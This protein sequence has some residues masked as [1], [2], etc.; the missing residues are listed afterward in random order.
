MW[1]RMIHDQGPSLDQDLPRQRT[2]NL[3]HSF[4]HQP[5]ADP[6][7]GLGTGPDPIPQDPALP[8]DMA[9]PDNQP[10]TMQHHPDHPD[11]VPRGRPSQVQGP[12]PGTKMQPPHHHHQ[13][14]HPATPIPTS[15]LPPN[16][17]KPD[18]PMP[19]QPS[20]RISQAS[21]PSQHDNIPPMPSK[22]TPKR[23]P[24]RII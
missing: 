12:P 15:E 2:P 10:L 24:T 11:H 17:S 3:G 14:H 22:L 21:Q 7:A 5:Q 6:M 8:S 4:R 20:R 16:Y 19:Q 18:S 13:H 1:K 9:F 23:L